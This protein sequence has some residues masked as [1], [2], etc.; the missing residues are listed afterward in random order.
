MPEGDS[1]GP[2]PEA[3]IVTI[4]SENSYFLPA[5]INQQRIDLLVDTGSSFSIL[6]KDTWDRLFPH[7]EP[8]TPSK[9]AFVGVDGKRLNVQGSCQIQI[10]ICG[11]TFTLEVYVID[12]ITTEAIVGLDFLVKNHACIDTAAGRLIIPGD[13]VEAKLRRE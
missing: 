2:T 7:G 9:R 1:S 3:N 6:R 8:L 4:S 10:V 12:A 13:N 5:S 11:K